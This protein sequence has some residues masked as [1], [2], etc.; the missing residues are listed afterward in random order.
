MFNNYPDLLTT[1]EASDM[2]RISR[3]LLTDLIS[4]GEIPSRLIRGKRVI[5]KG[6]AIA[7][8]MK[9]PSCGY[10]PPHASYDT[11]YFKLI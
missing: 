6:A 5:P 8:Y 9:Q 4:S 2:L 3:R 1:A 11:T 7:W 10:F